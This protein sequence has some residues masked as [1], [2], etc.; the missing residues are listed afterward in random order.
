MD[1]VKVTLSLSEDINIKLAELAKENG[2]NKSSLVTLL[3]SKLERNRD[4]FN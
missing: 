3:V 2:L 1:K 4:I